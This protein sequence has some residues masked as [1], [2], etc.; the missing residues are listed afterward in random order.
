MTVGWFIP[1]GQVGGGEGT[2]GAPALHRP[3]TYRPDGEE[4]MQRTDTRPGQAGPHKP[5]STS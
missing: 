4:F 5:R 3:A 1:T 2:G